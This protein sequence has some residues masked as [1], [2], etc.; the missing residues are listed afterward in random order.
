MMTY[1]FAW[2]THCV[3]NRRINQVK[4]RNVPSY[5]TGIRSCGFWTVIIQTLNIRTKGSRISGYW[6]KWRVSCFQN[7]FRKWCPCR[8]IGCTILISKKFDNIYIIRMVDKH[9]I[10]SAITLLMLCNATDCPSSKTFRTYCNWLIMMWKKLDWSKFIDKRV[11]FKQ[12]LGHNNTF[13]FFAFLCQS[14]NS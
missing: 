11:P 1:P 12:T 9:L 4:T 5:P 8:W 2:Y 3:F 7:V 6:I 14:N 10:K 13:V